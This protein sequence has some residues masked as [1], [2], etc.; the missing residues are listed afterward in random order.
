MVTATQLQAGDPR[1]QPFF[2]AC[3]DASAAAALETLLGGETEA[4][5]GETVRRALGGSG[6]GRAHAPDV[7]GD[8]RLRLVR[9]LWSLR[10]GVGEPIENFLGYVVTTAEH[11]AYAFL[12]QQYPERTRFRN[13]VRYATAHHAGTM[14]SSDADG[15]WLC[16]TGRAV[17]PAPASGATR[18]F[19]DDPRSWFAARRIDMLQA[20]PALLDELLVQLDEAIELDRLVDTLAGILGIVDARPVAVREGTRGSLEQLADPAAAISEVLEQRQ[21]LECVW[22]EI[23][24]LPPRQRAAL[25]LNLRDP[26]GGAVLQLLPSTGVA[27]TMQIA[28]ALE[29][30]TTQLARI[31]DDLPLDD[32]S[33]ADRLGVTRQQ[34]INLRKSARAR[35]ARRVGQA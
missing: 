19:L 6:V 15:V 23:E 32:L 31:W 13:R 33:I 7:A 3:T 24:S 35:L 14:L 21:H 27:S 5:V 9:K 11:G 17:R 2:D 20:L 29:I 34:V 16:R 22:R 12:R 30:G 28:A 8:V 26:Q 1:L 25:L 10:R 4:V 18:A